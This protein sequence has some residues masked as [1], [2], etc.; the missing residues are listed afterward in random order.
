MEL[1]EQ[2]NRFLLQK[3]VLGRNVFVARGAVVAGAVTLGDHSSVWYNA[4]LRGDINRIVVGH[5]SNLQ[6][7]CVAH[8]SDDFPCLV[9]N[10]VTVGHGA[11]IHACTV[12]DCSLVGM[13]AVVLDG[14]VIGEE[15]LIAA[16]A[17]VPQ[18]MRVPPRSLVV[19]VP[20]RVVRQVTAEERAWLRSVAEK[21]ARL[22]AFCLERGLGAGAPEP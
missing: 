21:Y 6:D 5:H 16:R 10:H 17:L 20:G 2:L 11:I 12:G 22:G 7:N 14:A 4:V 8:L 19:G 13:G 15:S 3:P 1:E 9:G 18:G